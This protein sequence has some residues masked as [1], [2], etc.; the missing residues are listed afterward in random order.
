MVNPSTW[1]FV[2]SVLYS[3]P[4]C[5]PLKVKETI[6]FILA[7]AQHLRQRLALLNGLYLVSRAYKSEVV[8][9]ALIWISDQHTESKRYH[10]T[11]L[12]GTDCC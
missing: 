10:I 12:G 5:D 1:S 6:P 7:S 2:V 3:L 8:Y 9:L 4:D 11:A